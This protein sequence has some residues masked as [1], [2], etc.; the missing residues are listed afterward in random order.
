MYL[1]ALSVGYHKTG[2]I[3]KLARLV[4]LVFALTCP[5]G[6]SPCR[7]CRVSPPRT[8]LP[9]ISAEGVAVFIHPVK[10]LVVQRVAD[11]RI[12]RIV[13]Q[14]FALIRIG[15]KIIQ[16]VVGKQVY[17]QLHVVL[18]QTPHKLKTAVMVVVKLK[19]A[20]LDKKTVVSG[21]VFV[22]SGAQDAA[23]LKLLRYRKSEILHDRR[24]DIDMRYRLTAVYLAVQTVG[25]AYDKGDTSHIVICRRTLGKKTVT[26]EQIAMVGGV[27]YR[28]LIRRGVHDLADKAVNIRIAPEEVLVL[29][30]EF[31]TVGTGLLRRPYLLMYRLSLKGIVN[32]RRLGKF[33]S[34]IH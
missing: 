33:I 13:Y 6:I 26:A 20:E 32:R 2:S 31:V 24:A 18:H 25:R 11:I 34:R 4:F 14:V 29:Y 7:L 16:L 30:F 12:R 10:Q 22:V 17:Y 27:H 3:V 23:A 9:V 5:A 15:V 1:F 8:G 28:R 21:G 19:S